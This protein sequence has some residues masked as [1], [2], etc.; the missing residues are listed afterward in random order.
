MIQTIVLFDGTCN[1]CNAWIHFAIRHDSKNK[2][3]FSPLQ[4]EKSK[5]ILLNYNLDVTTINSVICIYKNQAY[6]QAEA[7]IVICKQLTGMGRLGFL[8][9][10][11]PQSFRTIIY[12]LIA[13]NRYRFWGKMDTCMIPNKEVSDRFL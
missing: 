5:S 6:I 3:K 13:K 1:F 2:L 10:L 12:N 9:V 4:S 11:L 8:L 7:V